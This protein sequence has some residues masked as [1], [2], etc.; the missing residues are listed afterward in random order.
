MV[1]LDHKSEHSM[2]GKKKMKIRVFFYAYRV[3]AWLI[4]ETMDK[5]AI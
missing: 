3:L 2:E 5:F 4:K 1:D